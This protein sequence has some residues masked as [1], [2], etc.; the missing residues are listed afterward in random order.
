MSIEKYGRLHIMSYIFLN[1][2]SRVMR[3]KAMWAVGRKPEE[4]RKKR[5]KKK[6]PSI[7]DMTPIVQNHVSIFAKK[8]FNIKFRKPIYIYH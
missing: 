7:H 2:Y 1:T 3:R 6:K 4:L 5:V 8:K